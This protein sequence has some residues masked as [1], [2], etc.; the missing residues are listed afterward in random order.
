MITDPERIRELEDD[1]ILGEHQSEID[2]I[3]K[4]R[5]EEWNN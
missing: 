2:Q 4:E 1:W 3:K 5:D